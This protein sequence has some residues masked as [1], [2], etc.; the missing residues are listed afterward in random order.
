VEPRSRIRE[1]DRY[2]IEDLVLITERE[3]KVLTNIKANEEIF[4]VS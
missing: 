3:P 1:K 2:H 4:T